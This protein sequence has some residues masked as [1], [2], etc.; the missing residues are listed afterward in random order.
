MGRLIP[1]RKHSGK[2][3]LLP[4]ITSGVVFGALTGFYSP[5]LISLTDGNWTTSNSV[6]AQGDI[7]GYA[8]ITDGD[9]IKINGT[10]VRFHGIDAPE[11]DQTCWIDGRRYSCGIE[12]KAFL[13]HIINNQP[14]NCF[15]ENTD[16]YGRKIAQC[17]N[18]KN[19]DIE[20]QM[21]SAGMAVAYTY[22]SYDYI[23][24]ETYA[25]VNGTGFW[26]GDFENPYDYR[27]SKRY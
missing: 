4:L 12:A 14:V 19:E 16:Q 26:A 15:T 9:T 11:I 2:N 10:R 20:A 24:E 18:Y 13:S 22:Y 23:V 27:R 3:T 5:D 1:F 7:S 25:R 8:M 6:Q 17:Y 21:V